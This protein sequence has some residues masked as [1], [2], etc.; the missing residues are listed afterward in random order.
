MLLSLFIPFLFTTAATSEHSMT[1]SSSCKMAVFSDVDGTLVHYPANVDERTADAD[2][3]N[4]LMYLPPSKTGQ[5]GVISSKTLRLCQKLRDG[6]VPFVLVSGMRSTTLFQR[7]P[8]LPRA[9]A[10]VSESGGR[11]FYPHSA[12]DD[13][14]DGLVD[15]LLVYPKEYTGCSQSHL[16]PFTLV[17]DLDW[18][19]EISKLECAGLDGYS[20]LAPRAG[21]DGFSTLTPPVPIEHRKGALW[22]HA[23]TLQKQGF[24]LDS[25]GYAT[26]FRVNRKH[27]ESEL[28]LNFDAFLQKCNNREDIPDE[29]GCSTNLGCVD[30]FPKMSGKKNV[31]DYLLRKFFNYH[32]ETI[33]LKKHA[34][35]LCDDDND[36]EMALACHKAYL[37]SV[38]SESI[39]KLAGENG[40]M[41]I[42]ESAD[43]GIV[44]SFATE[45]ALEMILRD[46][47]I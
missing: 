21:S 14:I 46:I 8:Y 40:H 7:L 36:I 20:I 33:S 30:F 34:C 16:N 19:N 23:Q 11:I 15:G 17:E 41:I 6:G 1:T 2:D 4:D 32:D 45:A 29:L 3:G 25:S 12:L 5:R 39:R 35:C 38:T 43:E 24:F 22:Q 28:A 18:R 26:A 47:Q 13:N 10:Y 9:D 31:C 37:P 27:Q 42:T 44:E